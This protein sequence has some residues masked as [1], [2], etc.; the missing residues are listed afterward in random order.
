MAS[1]RPRAFSDAQESVMGTPRAQTPTAPVVGD[2]DA[3][4]RA[5]MPYCL[6]IVKGPTIE[7]SGIC[8]EPKDHASP[9]KPRDRRA[10]AERRSGGEDRRDSA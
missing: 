5:L 9:C 2:L 3:W 1:E 10:Q 8:R 7:E 6:R 4:R